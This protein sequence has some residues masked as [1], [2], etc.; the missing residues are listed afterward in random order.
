[1]KKT[2]AVFYF[3]ITVVS[4]HSQVTE[5]WGASDQSIYKMDANGENIDSIYTFN[6]VDDIDGRSPRLNL[7]Y[8]EDNE[9]FYGVTLG[10][11]EDNAGVIYS[12][13]PITEDV[14][15]LADFDSA[16]TGNFPGTAFIKYN[17]LYY[18]NT[19]E[20]GENNEGTIYTFNPETNIIDTKKHLDLG[21]NGLPFSG[22]ISLA[23]N[24]KFYGS[25]NYGG[26]NN[27]GFLYEYDPATDVFVTKF[28]FNSYWDIRNG[29]IELDNGKMY[30][31]T[32]AGGST[33][34]GGTIVEYTP[35]D[36]TV[37]V[38]CSFKE[39]IT[40][41]GAFA[42]LTLSDN[43]KLYG[44][45]SDGGKND[46]GTIFEY[47][48]GADTLY[49]KYH[50]DWFVDGGNSRT[51][52]LSARN[53]NLYGMTGQGVSG[54]YLG[55]IFEYIPGDDTVTVKHGFAHFGGYPGYGQLAEITYSLDGSSI[56]ETKNTDFS[57]SCFP[58]PTKGLITIKHSDELFDCT[59]K[60][61][62]MLGEFVSQQQ[63]LNSNQIDLFIEGPSGVYFVEVFN[64]NKS[65]GVYKVIKE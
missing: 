43:G 17:G 5:F 33:A 34:G 20:G 8:D 31:V 48:P 63:E 38:K 18:G 55:A 52:L 54:Y 6:S 3:V 65:I 28:N 2:I 51:N 36:D 16:L 11:G 35:G 32:S 47:T 24:N 41:R 30:G 10:G 9:V 12:I 39:E 15:K 61:Y 59:V 46:Y 4:I 50:F 22:T 40:G 23:S 25:I 27:R 57:V 19:L 45:T 42:R 44:V 58:N 13:D 56:F 1:M 49:V 53:G 21:A 29:F 37:Y 64:K 14:I 60:T 7:T 26:P 62:T